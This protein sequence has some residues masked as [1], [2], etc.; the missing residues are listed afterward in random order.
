M[1]VRKEIRTRLIIVFAIFLASM[2]LAVGQIISLQFIQNEKWEEELAKYESAERVVEAE[3][4]DILDSE[5]RLLASTIPSYK[6]YMDMRAGGLSKNRHLFHNNVDSLSYC[7]AHLIKDKSASQYKRDLQSAYR[8][9]NRYYRVIRRKVSY[10]EY[11]QIK[12]FPL[13]RKGQNTSG[14]IAEKIEQR[15]LPFGVLAARTIG[16]YSASENRGVVGIENAFDDQLKG[17]PGTEIR[18]KVS[19][20]WISINTID[21]IPGKNVKT[22]INIDIQDIVETALL[23]QMET[24]QP[25]F[26]TAIVMEV[27]T[28]DI[29]AIANLGRTSNGGY[30]EKYNYAIG[31]LMEPGSTFKL[32][33]FM[34]ALEDGVINL[35]DSIDTGDGKFKFYD[36]TLSDSHEGGYGKISAKEVFER[37]S[38]IGT[39]KIINNNYKDNPQKYVDR[40][41]AMSLNEKLNIGIKGE[42]APYIKYPT[43]DPKIW[44]GITLPWMSMGY[45]VALLPLHTLTFYNAVANDGK[46]VKPRLVSDI[47]HNGKSVKHYKTK[48]INPSIC[49]KSTIKQAQQLLEG[50]VEN[51]TA[52]NLKESHL[53]IAGKTGTARVAN[54]NEGYSKN[55]SFKY[56]ASF[57]GYFP[58]ENPMYSCIVLVESPSRHSIYGNVVAGKVF[59]EIADKIYAQ[60]YDLQMENEQVAEKTEFKVPVTMD[61]NRE[62]LIEVF[63]ELKTEI[64]DK[65]HQQEW[66]KTYNKNNH[67]ELKDQV[68]VDNLMPDVKGM[69]AKDAVFLLENQGLKVKIHGSGRVKYQSIPCGTRIRQ[70]SQVKLELS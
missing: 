20:S 60:T 18:K 40:L 23:K 4:G 22:T 65:G 62:E 68:F 1:S 11:K 48:V 39:A 58:A 43:N 70:G 57:C 67:I 27:K 56:R 44:S 55:S 59:R 25:K 29:K 5:G 33:S 31:E 8:S 32:A 16:T 6:I 41:Y 24:H 63:T 14:F 66:I 64:T 36:R 15:K 47:M 69:G 2:L 30:W 10:T 53:K 13:F 34:V 3:R 17:V 38:N 45:E 54:D 35:N 49:S 37:S 26:G 51:G 42:R 52:T 28:G 9:G 12:Q 50:V 7:L 21:P 46:M 61:G 19:G